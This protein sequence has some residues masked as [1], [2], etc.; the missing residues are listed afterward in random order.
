MPNEIVTNLQLFTLLK[1]KDLFRIEKENYIE[2]SFSTNYFLPVKHPPYGAEVNVRSSMGI[3]HRLLTNN[4]MLFSADYDHNLLE[5]L[6]KAVENYFSQK[7]IGIDFE[8]VNLVNES[9]TLDKLY[10]LSHN[11]NFMSEGN[12]KKFFKQYWQAFSKFFYEKFHK[13][14]PTH[15]KKMGIIGLP[16]N[17]KLKSF[18]KELCDKTYMVKIIANEE[19][20]D[21]TPLLSAEFQKKYNP[22]DPN[23][24]A[25]V[26]YII[27]VYA[28]ASQ[29]LNLPNLIYL[30]LS[31]DNFKP[32][33]TYFKEIIPLDNRYGSPEFD[34]I[35]RSL[36]Q[37]TGRLT[38]L[39]K[40]QEEQIK[41]IEYNNKTPYQGMYFAALYFPLLKRFF[42]KIIIVDIELYHSILLNLIN[43]KKFKLYIK[44][45]NEHF[46]KDIKKHIKTNNFGTILAKFRIRLLVLLRKKRNEKELLISWKKSVKRYFFYIL[47]YVFCSILGGFVKEL[48][49]TSE[50]KCSLLFFSKF[51]ESYKFLHDP[52]SRQLLENVKI[53]FDHIKELKQKDE[54]EILN[55]LHGIN[56]DKKK[57]IRNVIPENHPLFEIDKHEID[58]DNE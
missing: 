18:Y 4:V 42:K 28:N 11:T 43:S 35:L 46:P 5:A 55:Y 9:T 48:A 2:I 12:N 13:K 54:D 33:H 19:V 57:Y 31:L 21:I 10:I 58:D 17:K 51:R 36:I 45:Y 3:V 39:E 23:P 27:S 22:S 34:I 49:Y 37:I 41:F 50:K 1:K 40:D 8:C 25:W 44:I 6:Q 16:S 30:N 53:D 56:K 29:G 38:R 24:S 52:F 7:K 15:L 32:K 20:S 14:Q 47:Y 26:L